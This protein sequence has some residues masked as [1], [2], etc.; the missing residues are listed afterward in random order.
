[1]ITLSNKVYY[2]LR[3]LLPRQARIAARRWLADRRRRRFAATWPIDELAG[4]TPPGWPGWPG[5]KKFALVLTHD[6]EGPTGLGR[7]E[8]L[9][10]LE[11]RQ[12]F[13]SSFNFVPEGGYRVPGTLRRRLEEEGFEVGVH[14]LYHD[15]K[16]FFSRSGFA[17]RAAKIREYVAE[18]NACGFR[19]PLMHHKLAWQHVFGTDYDA[20]TFDTDP[21]E[22]ESDG[23]RTIFPF[24]VAAPEGGGYVE[25]P[26]TLVQDFNMF[27]I[28]GERGI[29]VWKQKLD[30]IAERGGMALIN[31][32]P[33]YL[34]FEGSPSPNEAASAMYEE[35]LR[36]AKERHGGDYW[37]AL[38]RDVARYYKR[39]IPEPKR[40]SRRKVCLISGGGCAIGSAAD[41]YAKALADRGDLVDVVT[42][43]GERELETASAEGSIKI[44]RLHG[45]R[46]SLGFMLNAA[47]LLR[48][49]DALH[50]YELIHV[51]DGPGW[52]VFAALFPKGRGVRVILE[53]ERQSCTEDSGWL[54]RAAAQFS[55]L[56]VSRQA[57]LM[58]GAAV[59]RISGRL[60]ETVRAAIRVCARPTGCVPASAKDPGEALLQASERWEWSAS[61]ESSG[62]MN[63]QCYL[64]IAD[65]LMTERFDDL[66]PNTPIEPS[67]PARP[68]Y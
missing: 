35:F 7:V 22:P 9:M 2:A 25:L 39:S 11:R 49:R 47:L 38:A 48:R 60:A 50:R 29:D 16:L 14:G 4:T 57:D 23:V 45:R 17:A 21:F 10:E 3:P 36:Y 28:L 51:L 66:L 26:Y 59:P 6:V 31:T 15:G 55:D 8:R 63:R 37:Q 32:H 5:G 24:W 40:N 20:S 30:W 42:T 46:A 1:M 52:L 62:A 65:A 64:L 56:I 18:W 44:H 12:G 27:V 13:R 53:Q 41:C 33:D 43:G 19:S 54:G 58:D 68:I 61:W 34:C 67:L